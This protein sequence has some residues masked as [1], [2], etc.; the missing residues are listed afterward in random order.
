MNRR[1]FI[2]LLFGAVAGWPVAARAQQTAVPVVGF[3]NPRSPEDTAHLVAMFQR[4]LAESGYVDGQN[5]KIEYRWALGQYDRLPAYAVELARRP[6]D[7]IATSGGE[8]AAL[9][10]KNATATIPIVFAVG[11]DPVGF[12]LVASLNRPGGNLTG[13]IQ[14]ADALQAKRLGLLHEVVPQ[15][16]LIG[17]LLNPNFPPALHQLQ[18]LQEAAEGIGLQ[19]YPLRAS[20]DQEIGKAFEI[21]EQQ[22]IA[23]L[24]LAG[25]PFFDTR[26]EMLVALAA[27][28]SVTAMYH[29]RDYTIAGG[30][31]SYGTNLSD[32]YH[33]VGVYTGKILRGAK[34]AVLPVMQL[35]KFKLVLNLKTAKTLGIAFSPGLLAIADEVIE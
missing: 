24:A 19:I 22:R 32:A 17:V 35:A 33:Q 11:G 20:T 12:G 21:I 34:P 18:D 2:T 13:V 25:D 4:G 16:S 9:A 27:R 10:A 8:P 14:F 26:R 6:V 23:A 30:L 31:M 7:V 28:Y 3:L 1:E 15:A 29:F 5:V